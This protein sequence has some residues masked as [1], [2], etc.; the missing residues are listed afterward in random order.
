MKRDANIGRATKGL[1]AG[2]NALQLFGKTLIYGDCTLPFG[3]NYTAKNFP[4]EG[5]CKNL[6]GL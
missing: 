5:A 1:T 2:A 3:R 6:Q 4:P